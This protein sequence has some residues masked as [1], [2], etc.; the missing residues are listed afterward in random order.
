MLDPTMEGIRNAMHR[1]FDALLDEP[2]PERWIE[3]IKRLNA[4]EDNRRLSAETAPSGRGSPRA[5][6]DT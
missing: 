1:S 2:L 3:L 5:M 6:R 4:E